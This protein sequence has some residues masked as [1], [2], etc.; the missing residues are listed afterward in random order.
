MLGLSKWAILCV[1]IFVSLS[2]RPWPRSL[3]ENPSSPPLFHSYILL[4]II[5]STIITFL[6]GLTNYHYMVSICQL[7]F[8]VSI[9]QLLLHGIDLWTIRMTI[10]LLVSQEFLVWF[11]IDS[12]NHTRHTLHIR[13][14]IWLKVCV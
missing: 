9:C 14:S 11:N 10:K 4:M 12:F 13:Y 6:F 3:L 1:L 5:S 8:M 2:V 7:L